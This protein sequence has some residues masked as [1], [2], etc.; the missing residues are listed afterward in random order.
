[1]RQ[2]SQAQAVGQTAPKPACSSLRLRQANL[3]E[4]LHN[5]NF[6]THRQRFI[7]TFVICKKT[8]SIPITNAIQK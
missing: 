5:P 3:S 1:M 7:D 6:N 4:Y 2:S 8:Y